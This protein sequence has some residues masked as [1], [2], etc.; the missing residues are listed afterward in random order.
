MHQQPHATPRDSRAHPWPGFWLQ[1]AGVAVGIA[2]SCSALAQPNVPYE[3]VD[4]GNA[5]ASAL[6]DSLR[7]VPV[8]LRTPTGFDQVFRLPTVVG[9]EMFA[10]MDGGLTAVFP[11]SEYGFGRPL[12]PAGTTWYIGALPSSVFGE[13][14][15]RPGVHQTGLASQVSGSGRLDQRVNQRAGQAPPTVAAPP[16]RPGPVRNPLMPWSGELERGARVADLL[17]RAARAPR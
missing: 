16:A 6:A 8:D 7:L 5:D 10:R 17:S 13:A 11:R 12:I 9:G 1:F 2:L 4:P 15:P 3:V 14:G